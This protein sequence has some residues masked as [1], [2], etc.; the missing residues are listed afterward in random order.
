MNHE[1]GWPCRRERLNTVCNLY[2]AMKCYAR[3]NLEPVTSWVEALHV[4]YSN[5]HLPS[6]QPAKRGRQYIAFQPHVGSS[7]QESGGTPLDFGRL[8]EDRLHR[9]IPSGSISFNGTITT[10]HSVN[11]LRLPVFVMHPF[12]QVR[13]APPTAKHAKHCHGL[14]GFPL[15]L[16]WRPRGTSP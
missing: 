3:R 14:S 9:Q 6:S 1:H 15:S 4:Q 2:H 8:I 16:H 11:L 10:R 5:Q 12:A 7:A 13:A